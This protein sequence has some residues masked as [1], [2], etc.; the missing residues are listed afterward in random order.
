[1]PTVILLAKARH[2]YQLKF[3]EKQLGSMFEG[4]EFRMTLSRV[5]PQ[6]LIQVTVSGQDQNV[7][8]N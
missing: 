7:I 8:L 4:L 5:V 2:N 3:L 6:N 1:V